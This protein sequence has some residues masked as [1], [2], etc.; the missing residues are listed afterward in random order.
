MNILLINHYA[1]S[2]H[3]GMEYRSYYLA[4]EWVGLGHQVSIVAASFSHVRTKQPE[5]VNSVTKE[6]VD[7]IEYYWLKTPE[8]FGNGIKRA[9]NIYTFISRLYLSST[10][11]RNQVNPDVVIASSTYPLDIFPASWIAKRSQAR[12]VYEIHDLWPLTPIELGGMSK[13]N[14]FIM[15][16]QLA[17]DFACKHAHKIISIL[18][19]A[20]R[21]LVTRG[22]DRNKYY[23]IPNGV[24]VDEWETDQS[25]V[26]DEHQS[27]IQK[28][29]EKGNY[30][31]GYAGAHG[32]SNALENLIHAAVLLKD[33]PI[34]FVLVG[35][36][37]EKE[38][39]IDQAKKLGL[40]DEN[41]V[42]LPPVPKKA[43]PG[44]LDMM[45]FLYI[46]LR[47]SSLFRYGVSP[48][49]LIDYMMAGKPIINAIEASNDLVQES[50]CGITVRA[51]DPLSLAEGI[52]QMI[53]LDKS[54]LLEMGQKGKD[55]ALKNHDYKVLARR[56]LECI[57]N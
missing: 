21:Y 9:V 4:R 34:T 46:G 8:Y 26:P 43:I 56:F 42:F 41:V 44:L 18:P 33:A 6:I 51:E 54:T 17:E 27:A 13:W 16:L 49:K 31:I 15:S 23:A 50:R 10:M 14:P 25:I 53:E 48:N 45:D 39:L 52:R 1:G 32:I 47:K 20:D 12:L 37:P 35:N 22:M 30:I 29:M 28:I 40:T 19:H 38:K 11:I 36:G 3:H 5:V 55:Y 24:V 57:E 2:K 7:G